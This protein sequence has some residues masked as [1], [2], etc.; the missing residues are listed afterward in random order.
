MFYDLG[1][2]WQQTAFT[3][4]STELLIGFVFLNLLVVSGKWQVD[5]TSMRFGLSLNFENT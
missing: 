3:G 4:N 2:F 5:G 1:R